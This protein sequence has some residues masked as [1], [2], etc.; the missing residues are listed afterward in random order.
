[1]HCTDTVPPAAYVSLCNC[2]LMLRVQVTPFTQCHFSI[3]QS[4]HDLGH[5]QQFRRRLIEPA[6]IHMQWHS[7]NLVKPVPPPY[8]CDNI[9]VLFIVLYCITIATV[10]SLASWYDS[11]PFHF[12]ILVF[13]LWRWLTMMHGTDAT[14]HASCTSAFNARFSLSLY[15]LRRLYSVT[16]RRWTNDQWLGRSLKQAGQTLI[17]PSARHVSVILPFEGESSTAPLIVFLAC[18]LYFVICFRV[19]SRLSA[20]TFGTT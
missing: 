16:S 2:S 10:M 7:Q 9:V 4:V 6:G 20:D 5:F 17:A 1:M 8:Y 12:C 13:P 15:C 11:I 3:E 14:L 18:I 19:V